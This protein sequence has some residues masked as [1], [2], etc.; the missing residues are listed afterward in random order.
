MNGTYKIVTE[1]D[2][3]KNLAIQDLQGT[4]YPMKLYVVSVTEKDLVLNTVAGGSG[5]EVY[6]RP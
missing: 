5:F 6:K 2:G 1:D 3:K 4:K